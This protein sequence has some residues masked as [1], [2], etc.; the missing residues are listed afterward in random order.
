MSKKKIYNN[1]L[2]FFKDKGLS[3]DLI[4]KY[5]L[6]I[7]QLSSNNVPIIFDFKHLTLLLGRQGFYLSSVINSPNNHYRTFQIKKR[8]GG[9]RDIT[10]PYPALLEMQYWIYNNILKSISINS[11]AH[12]FTFK[13]SIV[14]NA[15]IHAGQKELLKL[16]LKDFFPSI[17]FNRIIYIFK[18]L[19][20]PNE[21]AFYLASICSYNEC[22]PQGAPTS[23]IISNIVAKQLDKRLISLAKK[24]NL[25]Y[26]RYAD[27]L[28][29]SGDR[30][31]T[32]LID[33]ISNI[34][35]DEGFE[36]N[37]LKTR[38]Y[39]DNSKRIVTG[40]SVLGE[41]LKIPRE[42]K[43]NLH[44]ELNFIFKYGFESHVKKM[45]IRSSSYLFSI[46]GKINF[47]LMVEPNND[48]AK[49][50]KKKIIDI[51]KSLPTNKLFGISR[52]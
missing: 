16:D 32:I 26:T 41:E 34:V 39:R 52:D 12:G 42:Y 25:K 3:E 20:Y 24:Y 30:V 46:L 48:F 15:K 40:I 2:T 4:E 22:L 14:T 7:A 47:W 9:L 50:S 13:K 44:Q 35:K 33:Y 1:W 17:N 27:D 28:T 18:T 51:Y 49:E 8:S 21:I 36:V 19:G 37:K 43:R 29:F 10:T 31:P 6:Y 11:S 38:F 45:K 23:P 5:M